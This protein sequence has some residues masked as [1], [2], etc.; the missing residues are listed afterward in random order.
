MKK[1][2]CVQPF[3]A[4]ALTGQSRENN[5]PKIS[6]WEVVG[7]KRLPSWLICRARQLG[8]ISPT[9]VQAL[10][11]STLLRGSDA[12]IQAQTGSGKTLAYLMPLLATI[13]IENGTTQGIVVLQK[14]L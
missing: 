6:S 9:I 3:S 11:L 14:Q 5:A 12:V 4:K 13:N 8:F 2:D 1:G 10:T 7:D